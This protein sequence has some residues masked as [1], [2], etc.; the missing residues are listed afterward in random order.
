M[1]LLRNEDFSA[2]NEKQ[3]HLQRIIDSF[4]Y[5]HADKIIDELI[6]SVRDNYAR[7]GE[8]KGDANFSDEDSSLYDLDLYNKSS[9]GYKMFVDKIAELLRAQDP[10]YSSDIW[11]SYRDTAPERGP[12]SDE[13]MYV[14]NIYL[15][16]NYEGEHAPE[17]SAHTSP[18]EADMY[19]SRRFVRLTDRIE[20]LPS[21]P[22]QH[23]IE[24]ALQIPEVD[25]ITKTLLLEHT[26]YQPSIDE[27]Y[28]DDMNVYHYGALKRYRGDQDY[29]LEM[30]L[31][32]QPGQLK[33]RDDENN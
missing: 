10:R 2:R 28:W 18:A 21:V 17:E 32:M 7:S 29:L 16:M 9:E 3:A 5:R 14:A 25:H 15:T 13:N 23:K 27:R 11:V 1:G 33:Y 26:E 19:W 6:K 30:L 8:L 24:L 4:E 31:G 22:P 12:R 20:N